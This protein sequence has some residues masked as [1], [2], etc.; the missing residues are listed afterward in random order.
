MICFFFQNASHKT[1]LLFFTIFNYFA[2]DI[3]SY[4][5]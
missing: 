5:Y 4:N 2:H 1:R 3:H